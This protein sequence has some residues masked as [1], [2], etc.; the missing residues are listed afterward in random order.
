VPFF[1]R[2]DS[3]SGPAEPYTLSPNII[4]SA[5]NVLE[6]LTIQYEP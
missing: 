6:P 3:G 5:S 2:I 4:P 1:A